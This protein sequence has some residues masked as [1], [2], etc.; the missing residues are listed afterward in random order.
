MNRLVPPE[1]GAARA[2]IG[3]VAAR[4]HGDGPCPDPVFAPTIPFHLLS[5]AQ[6]YLCAQDLGHATGPSLAVA[7]DQFA[8][9]LDPLI[10]T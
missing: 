4:S 1:H 10:R 9:S 6:I 5:L 3:V 7:W 2:P 8:A